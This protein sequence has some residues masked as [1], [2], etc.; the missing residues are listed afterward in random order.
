MDM[1]DILQFLISDPRVNV[2]SFVLTVLGVVLT[3]VFYLR[4]MNIKEPCYSIHSETIITP[5]L[6]K[7]NPI[8]ITFFDKP[9]E[10]LS[11]THVAFWNAG[12]ATISRSDMTEV[13][14]LRIV[15]DNASILSVNLVK[16]NKIANKFEFVLHPD[17]NSIRIDFDF[18]DHM[19]GAV[20][21]IYHT[22]Q[23]S[24]AL[25]LLGTI[26]GAT[27]LHDVDKT[28]NVAVDFFISRLDS[29][30]EMPFRLIP[31]WLWRLLDEVEMRQNFIYSYLLI[32]LLSILFIPFFV[33]Y[34]FFGFI[35]FI[36]FSLSLIPSL[37]SRRHRMP[38]ELF[39]V[40]KRL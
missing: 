36:L 13:D 8:K 28:V 12:R 32:A 3:I 1:P 22:G 24:D 15:T 20:I 35:G 10:N 33:L 9:V 29:F 4:S 18:I 7:K 21:A 26:K 19:N 39:G 40:I 2:V 25:Q 16:E 14:P 38:K 27:S 34:V 11:L 6:A 17:N 5:E 37:F 23:S 31:K 30:M